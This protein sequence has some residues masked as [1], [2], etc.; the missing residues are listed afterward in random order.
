MPSRS[1]AIALL[2]AMAASAASALAA[3]TNTNT[4]TTKP[5]AFFLAGDSMTAIQSTDGGGYGNGFLSFLRAPAWG[6]NL[7]HDGA[8]T[9]S[10]VQGGDWANLLSNVTAAAADGYQ[11]FVTIMV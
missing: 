7:G 5:P 2:A 1:S 9:V 11:P 6:L 4:N 8:T 10:F 3:S